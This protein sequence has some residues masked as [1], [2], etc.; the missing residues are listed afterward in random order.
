MTAIKPALILFAT[1][2]VTVTLLGVV[3]TLTLDPIEVQRKNA[4]EAAL[5]EVLPRAG[6]FTEIEIEPTG[7]IDKIFAG[8]AGGNTVGYVVELSP[9]G[10]G[11]TILLVVGISSETERLSGMRV[12]KH[13]ET[14]GLGARAVN[15]DFYRKFDGRE[16]VPLWVVKTSPGEYEI[17]AISSST[18]TTRAVTE[19][20]NEAIDWYNGGGWR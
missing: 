18:I 11:G 5:R 10:Y 6:E 2:V 3:Y 1:A 15:E 12:V 13:S 9:E 7:S 14:P 19:A 8:T 4:E 17:D 20:V 16:L